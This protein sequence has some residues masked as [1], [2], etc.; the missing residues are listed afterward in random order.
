MHKSAKPIM[1][2]VEAAKEAIST[3][4]TI[5]RKTINRVKDTGLLKLYKWMHRWATVEILLT[6]SHCNARNRTWKTDESANK[7]RDVCNVTEYLYSTLNS[8]HL[9]YICF[10]LPWIWAV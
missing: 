1:Q 7:E 5:I 6:G 4:C 10:G 3:V 9:L 2:C 8:R